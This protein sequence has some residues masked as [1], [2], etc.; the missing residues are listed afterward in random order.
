[1]ND[2]LRDIDQCF[3]GLTI[4][5]TIASV[6]EAFV[7]FFT[8]ARKVTHFYLTTLEAVS[9]WA[10][11]VLGITNKR[12][13]N[14]YRG[15]ELDALASKKDRSAVETTEH[16]ESLRAA[17]GAALGSRNR[18]RKL[19]KDIPCLAY[20]RSEVLSDFVVNLARMHGKNDY[21]YKLANIAEHTVDF[22]AAEDRSVLKLASASA[23]MSI[24]EWRYAESL[25]TNLLLI[26]KDPVRLSVKLEM[27]KLYSKKQD[28]ASAMS[29][30]HDAERLAKSRH[31]ITWFLIGSNLASASWNMAYEKQAKRAFHSALEAFDTQTESLGRWPLFRS[32]V[33]ID[34][35]LQMVVLR[36]LLQE[37]E[38][39]KF[40][41]LLKVIKDHRGS[42]SSQV[43]E[44]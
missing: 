9:G 30:Y 26:S 4:E 27:G 7:L 24:R 15:R 34:A 32:S 13:P 21:I 20:E 33:F 35:F 40:Q 14:V 17:I 42:S 10:T 12:D 36:S 39:S 29:C 23:L 5:E 22:P 2:S 44:R 6:K 38:D 37:P 1:M 25:L 8:P 18:F 16:D 43:I 3:Q 28:W 19:P 11:D 31:D 41:K